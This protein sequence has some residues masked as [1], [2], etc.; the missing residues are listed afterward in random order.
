ML[1]RGLLLDVTTPPVDRQDLHGLS[2]TGS[3][4]IALGWNGGRRLG[5]EA[6]SAE[7]LENLG[8]TTLVL[9]LH[10]KSKAIAS[11]GRDLSRRLGR[12]GDHRV[13]ACGFL[14]K[15]AG[16]SGLGAHHDGAASL[17]M[18]QLEGSRRVRLDTPLKDRVDPGPGGNRSVPSFTGEFEWILKPG[19][20]LAVPAWSPHAID[21]LSASVSFTIAMKPML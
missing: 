10:E 8:A 14:T 4:A 15:S 18:I 1:P 20:V 21:T 19:D 9:S 11:F 3:D 12:S 13:Y 6:A 16:P 2:R 5:V 7:E 17:F